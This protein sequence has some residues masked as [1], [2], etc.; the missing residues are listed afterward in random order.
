M[1]VAR[2]E[3]QKAEIVSQAT[4]QKGLLAREVKALR[5]ELERSGLSG[6]GDFTGASSQAQEVHLISLKL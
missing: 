5:D 2:L 3:A 6:A 1:E 4:A